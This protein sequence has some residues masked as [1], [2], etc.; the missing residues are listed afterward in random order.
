MEKLAQWHTTK[1][2]L[3]TFAVAELAITYGF[4]SLAIDRGSLI[5]YAL[6]II[7]LVGFAQNLV[8]LIWK[9]VHGNK[10]REA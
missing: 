8:K 6:A 9:L 1:W 10:T 3:L 5:W 2:G 4:G 7:F